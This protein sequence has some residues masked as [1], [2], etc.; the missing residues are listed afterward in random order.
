MAFPQL[1]NIDEKFVATIKKKGG[2]NLTASKL[3]PWI[4]ITSCL[5]DF[6][7]IESIKS[8]VSFAQRYGNT[9]SSGRVGVNAKGESVYAEKNDRGYRPSPII[10]SVDISQ[11]NE[12]LSKKTSF[13]IV[14]HSLGQAEL[15]LEYFQEPG[16]MVLVEWGD[17]TNLSY[18]QQTDI[19]KCDIIAYNNLKTIQ[20]KRKKAEG[21]YDAI[22][23]TIT[24]GSMSYGDQETFNI[25][26]NLTSVGE[27]PAYLQNHKGIETGKKEADSNKSFKQYEIDPSGTQ[28]DNPVGKTLFMQMFNKLPSAKRTEAI[29]NLQNEAWAIDP[30]NFINIDDQ[31]RE[32]LVDSA[33]EVSLHSDGDEDLKIPT[34]TPLFSNKSYIRVGLA[35]TIIDMQS[36]VELK[37]RK[38]GDCSNQATPNGKVNWYNT[39]CRAHKNIFSANSDYLYIAN[40]NAPSFDLIGALTATDEFKK[41]LGDINT[42]SVNLTDTTDIHPSVYGSFSKTSYFPNPYKLECPNLAQIDNTYLS[43]EADA[44]EWG[45][46]RDLYINFDFFC[47]TI[48]GP[49]L[50]NKDL[51]YKLLN[52][53]SSAVNMYWNFQIVQGATV[54]PHLAGGSDLFYDKLKKDFVKGSLGCEELQVVDVN[55]LGKV[56]DRGLGQAKF[57]SRGTKSPFLSAELNFDIP[58]AM[59]GQVIGKKLSNPNKEQMEVDFE[60]LFTDKTDSVAESL[61]VVKEEIEKEE[62][63]REEEEADRN[64]NPT[65]RAR[66]KANAARKK[67]REKEKAKEEQQKANYEL[68]IGS[69]S[70]FPRVQDRNANVDVAN[71]WY[72]WYSGNNIALEELMM[73]G[74]FDDANLLKKVQLMNEKRYIGETQVSSGKNP[75]LLPIKFTFTIFGVGGIRVGDTFCI[76]DLPNK[77]RNKIFQVTEIAHSVGTDAWR[78]TV[79]GKLRNIIVDVE[80]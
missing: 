29:Q 24:G 73:V 62:A 51:Y 27:L 1:A 18:S 2:N 38:I 31:I 43:Y 61:R 28:N 20:E 9:D 59:K 47:K 72:D 69:A 41:P 7:T 80:Q 30:Q 37:P 8:N 23:G 65:T 55:F 35:F 71:E 77:Y 48:S 70:V 13:T 76:T 39:V 21:R 15:I 50:T 66:A 67:Q 58:A 33:S 5:G 17:N 63:Q 74:C 46:L 49:L 79:T 68:F 53:M 14:A 54:E 36:S 4:R 56:K 16:N 57:Q 75:P 34:E 6:L 32:D 45:Y 52:G 44:G 26:V 40:K 22:L 42:Q 64:V 78:T 10:S 11:G 25:E 3:L 12:G 19:N 60:G